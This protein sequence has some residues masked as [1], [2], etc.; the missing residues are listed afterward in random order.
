MAVQFFR[1]MG[2]FT[3]YVI[4]SH[5]LDKAIANTTHYVLSEMRLA[6][7]RIKFK[8]LRYKR[9]HHL[10]LLGKTFYRL[11]TNDID[12]MHDEH[13]R[14]ISRVLNEI[15]LEIDQVTAELARRKQHEKQKK[16]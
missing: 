6:D 1:T 5:V 13:T 2:R 15:D 14:T 3:G 9:N 11:S 7:V 12:P 4:R 8:L 16:N 10:Y